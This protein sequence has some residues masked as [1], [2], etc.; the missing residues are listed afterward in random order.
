MFAFCYLSEQMTI[1]YNMCSALFLAIPNKKSYC[2]CYFTGTNIA[3]E[4]LFLPV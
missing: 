4:Y 1:S 2:I 3:T